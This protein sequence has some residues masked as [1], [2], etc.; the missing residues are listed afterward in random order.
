M[1]GRGRGVALWALAV[2]VAACTGGPTTTGS[3]DPSHAAT[4]P[5]VSM[6][7]SACLV[8]VSWEDRTSSR[9]AAWDEPSIRK[10]L[11][12]AG[13]AYVAT[14]AAASAAT[15]LSDVDHLIAE[16]VRV[17]VIN[18]ADR[19]AILPA[20]ASAT[21]QGIAVIAYDRLIDDPQVLYLSF[22]NVEVGRMQARAVLSAA[23]KGNYVF[24]KGDQGDANSDFLRSG[25]AEV[26]K[27]AISGGDVTVVGETYV[28]GWEPA[29]ANVDMIRF[30]DATGDKV[31]AVLAEND[32]LADGIMVAIDEHHLA[33]KVAISGQDGDPTGLNRVAL[34]T[35]TVDVWKDARL[36]GKAAA[37]AALELCSGT[38]VQDVTGTGTFDTPRGN[39]VS[40]ILLKPEAI[41][42]DNLTDVIGAG[43]IEASAVCQGVQP[44]TV[45]GCP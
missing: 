3:N 18:A 19:E 15:Q 17:L 36:L 41:T 13:A 8:G 40:S 25:Q 9:W 30:L 33:G 10:A 29:V 28:D 24:M 22:D 34:G 31:A 27:A 14:D 1:I 12:T 21:S 5:P 20:V 4:N 11:E 42:R 37:A 16:G 32:G 38:P 44:K 7:T 43:W 39:K 35:Q 23:P 26:L 2:A 6:P 45:A